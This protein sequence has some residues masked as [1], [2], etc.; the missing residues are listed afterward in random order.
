[1]RKS[2]TEHDVRSVITIIYYDITILFE[3]N[4]NNN[5]DI[6]IMKINLILSY[7]EQPIETDKC[8]IHVRLK[9]EI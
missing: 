8:K 5:L 9:H 3:V 6:T 4:T 7:D 2:I 1:M